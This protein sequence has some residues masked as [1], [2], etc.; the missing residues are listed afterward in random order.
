MSTSD[1]PDA[2]SSTARRCRDECIFINTGDKLPI[3]CNLLTGLPLLILSLF[4]L[5]FIFLCSTVHTQPH[6]AA[7]QGRTQRHEGTRAKDPGFSP[8]WIRFKT[9][10]KAVFAEAVEF[11]SLGPDVSFDNQAEHLCWQP[12]RSVNHPSDTRV[13][14]CQSTMMS[15]VVESTL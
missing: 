3:I 1:N 5:L 14:Y 11:K 12:S 7:D 8:I 13:T 9:S 10:I 2:N 4:L 15:V 6:H